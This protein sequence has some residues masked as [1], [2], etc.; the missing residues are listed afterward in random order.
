M[1]EKQMN[2]P[3]P[4]FA[5]GDRIVDVDGQTIATIE[6]R[7]SQVTQ[8][9]EDQDAA[10]A[11]LIAAAPELLEA[12]EDMVSMFCDDDRWIGTA[13]RNKADATLK[14]ARKGVEDEQCH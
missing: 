5:D 9:M 4:W 1:G 12:L 7:K 2:T 14:K 3:A 10:N 6:H 8:S 13:I 11:Y